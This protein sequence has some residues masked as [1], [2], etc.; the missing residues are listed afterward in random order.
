MHASIIK[1]LIK[2]KIN[3]KFAKLTG[4]NN[5]KRSTLHRFILNISN[6][7]ANPEENTQKY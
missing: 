1:T 7:A 5:L 3:V 6:V 2:D 4:N